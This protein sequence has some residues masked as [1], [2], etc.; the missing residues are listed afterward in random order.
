MT[1]RNSQTYDNLTLLKDV[2]A[3]TVD[4]PA[5]VASVARVLDMGLGRFSAKA[6]VDSAAVDLVDLNETYIVS[7][8]GS[9]SATFASGVVTLGS[10]TVTAAGRAEVHCTNEI[11]GVLYRYIRAY[12]DV[13]GTSP[14]INSTIYLA[15]H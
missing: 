6:I 9:N 2:S 12:I 3:V 13:G 10:G 8:Q 15:K 11:G 7:I 5:T 1:L 14:S 4:G